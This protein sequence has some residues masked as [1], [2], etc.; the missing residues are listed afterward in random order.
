MPT[1]LFVNG[2]IRGDSGN[3]AAIARHAL[4][5]LPEGTRG[6]ELVLASYGGTVEALVERIERADALLFGTGVYWGSW[7][8][9][10]QRFLEVLTS[11]ELE[12]CFLGKP[13]GAVVSSDSVGGLDVAQR[14]LG[15]LSLFGCSVPPL[16]TLV[17]SRVASA[18]G[19][20][21]ENDDVWQLADLEVVL[22]NL[23]KASAHRIEW[24][25][26]PARRLPRVTGVYPASGPLHG[27]LAKF[28]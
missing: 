8:S 9:P 24:A 11:Y 19:A 6:D 22:D 1:L 25:T 14:L 15:S 16:S 10:L 3:T 27:G 12:A 4:G 21:A 7:G 20:S 18:A 2:S 28:V 13:V 23:L 26:W 5:L 17:L